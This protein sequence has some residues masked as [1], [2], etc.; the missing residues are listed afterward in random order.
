MSYCFGSQIRETIQAMQRDTT[1]T[2]ERQK[3]GRLYIPGRTVQVVSPCN[4]GVAQIQDIAGRDLRLNMSMPANVGDRLT[5]KLTHDI[6]VT[7]EVVW[8]SNFDCT[9]ELDRQ[10]HYDTLLC[11]VDQDVRQAYVRLLPMTSHAMAPSP[12]KS[13]RQSTTLESTRRN[14]TIHR[15]SGSK[16]GLREK[17]IFSPG[18][19][20]HGVLQWLSANADF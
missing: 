4:R 3:K 16:E 12:S 2:M 7:G 6:S 18:V 8:C 17:I 14:M 10:I 20:R 13:A 1:Q 15:D 19:E 9:G 11:D 5:V